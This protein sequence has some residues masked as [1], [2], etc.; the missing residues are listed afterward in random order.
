MAAM[1]EVVASNRKSGIFEGMDK[2]DAVFVPLHL[3]YI[4]LVDIEEL[5]DRHA[6]P[7]RNEATPPDAPSQ[8]LPAKRAESDPVAVAAARVAESGAS[9][10]GWILEEL[11]PESMLRAR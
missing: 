5:G 10:N 4:E 8:L 1:E 3:A 7:V 2:I 11:R 6:R 9:G